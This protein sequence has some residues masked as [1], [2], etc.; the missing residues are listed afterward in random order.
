[1]A[2][3]AVP[4]VADAER[5]YIPADDAVVLQRVPTAADPRVRQLN[6][7]RANWEGHGRDLARSTALAAA[8]LDYGRANGDSRYLGRASAIVQPWLTL[9]PP[10]LPAMLVDAT[11]LQSR[12][13][14]AESRAE[15]LEIVRRDRD[16]GQAWLTLATVAQVQGDMDAARRACVHLIGGGDPLVAGACLSSVNLVTGRARDANSA[17]TDLLQR[18]PNAS[19]ELQSWVQG[20][21][22]DAACVL[23]DAR[24][25]DAHFRLAL[26]WTPG[27]N[28]LLADYADFLQDQGRPKEV[29]ALLKDYAQ[30]DTSFLRL[31][32]AEDALRDPQAPADVALMAARFAASDARGTP[33]FRR[34]EA[35]FALRL[36]HDPARALAM[37]QAN[38]SVQRAPRDAQIL[39]AAALAAGQPKA[40]REVLR[41]VADTG[42]EDPEVRS[43]A[44]RFAEPDR[45]A[46]PSG[47]GT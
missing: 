41:F 32:L 27:D 8:Y 21:L 37:A 40:A 14:F 34:E 39:L 9:A 23:G 33:L 1:M 44:A 4:C 31:V 16:N 2:S 22:A 42:L 11:I 30:S 38:W 26:Q 25:A 5:P 29:A 43:L 36:Q 12:H 6:V 3:V 10:A 45:F 17:L 24:A 15:L 18:E 7:L 13:N 47:S 19:A 35:L 20:L 28:F 46:S